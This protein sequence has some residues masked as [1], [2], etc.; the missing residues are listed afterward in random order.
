MNT[1]PAK[2]APAL[3]ALLER[4]IDY[5]GIY[6]P[7]AL[8]LETSVANYSS[9]QSGEFSWMLRWLV[10]GTNELQ[11]VP[12]S[13][14]GSI[15]LLSETDDARAAT[16]E[17]KG[18]VQAKHPV[19]CEIALANLDQLDAVKTAGNFAK[20]RTGGVKPEA[21]PS[22]KDVAA[23][24]VACAERRLPFKATAGLHHPIRAEYALTYEDDAPRAVMHGFLNVLMAAAFAWQGEKNIEAI[25]AETDATAFT[26][27]GG[28]KWRGLTLTVEQ[29]RDAREN[30]M[31]SIG[32]CSFDEPVHELQAL[33][34]LPTL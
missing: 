1:A 18:V 10:V 2:I 33:G 6:P 12:K 3:R 14:D 7:A 23:F 9:Y 30:F 24:I 26:F 25:I 32:S 8:P 22:P 34:L 11:S 15:S 16:I 5:A 28:A 4:L 19:Y 27:D 31:H 21:I 29:I 13:L 20:I 17:T